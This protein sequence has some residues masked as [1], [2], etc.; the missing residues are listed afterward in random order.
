MF[1]YIYIEWVYF[2]AI[3][4]TFNSSKEILFIFV[5]VYMHYKLNNAFQLQKLE[6]SAQVRVC[7]RA[8]ASLQ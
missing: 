8:T 7:N 1:V 2:Y 6:F 5:Q 3:N 4:I